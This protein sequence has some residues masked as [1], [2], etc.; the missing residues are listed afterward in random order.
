MSLFDK[1]KP[2]FLE[3][4]APTKG[5]YKHMFDFIR[6]WKMTVVLTSVV[7]LLPLCI[8]TLI[9]Y[10]E[11]QKSINSDI[12]LRTSR[13]ASNTKR[14][15]SSFLSEHKSALDFIV[16]DNKFNQLTDINR[17]SHILGNLKTG[18]GGFVDLGVVNKLRQ[19]KP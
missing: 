14:S 4:H 2:A 6:I 8:I 10:N 15:I 5:P 11:T 9:D 19:V 13:L 18:F 16:H 1:I 17:L 3:H 12:L 7:T